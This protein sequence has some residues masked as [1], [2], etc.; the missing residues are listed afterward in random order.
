MARSLRIQFPEAIYHVTSR[1]NAGQP[2]FLDDHDRDMFLEIVSRA[3]ERFNWL[4]HAYCLMPNHYHLVIQ[5]LDP[6]L[7][8]GMQ[9]VNGVYTQAFNRRHARQGHLFQGRF[10]AMLVDRDPYLLEL[11]RYVVRN[12]VRAGMVRR[13]S[14]WPWSSYRATAGIMKAPSFLTTEWILAQFATGREQAVHSYRRFVAR[15]RNTPIWEELR[16]QIYLGNDAFIAGL[17]G[18]GDALDGV[19]RVQRLPDRPHLSAILPVAASQETEAVSVA[20]LEYGYTMKEIADHLGVHYS[21]VSRW[22][23]RQ[24]KAADA[25]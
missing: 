20:Y 25:S 14:D 6:T 16:G 2:T 10:K 9:Y 7:S 22:I 17:P 3:V 21:T 18:R 15:K 5:T 8:R 19:P 11:T 4:C 24:E 13:A 12:P 23:H 1:G